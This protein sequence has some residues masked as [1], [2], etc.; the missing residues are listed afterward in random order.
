MTPGAPF[1]RRPS[2]SFDQRVAFSGG[3]EWSH[4]RIPGGDDG[5]TRLVHAHIGRV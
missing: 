1:R 4:M 3:T 5:E 2:S